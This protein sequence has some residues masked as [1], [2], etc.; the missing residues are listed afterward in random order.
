MFADDI[1][2][3]KV[4][5]ASSLRVGGFAMRCIPDAILRHRNKAEYLIIERKTTNKV[6]VPVEGWP[7]VEAQLWCYSLIDELQ[8]A[9][10]VHLIGQLWRRKFPQSL[11]LVHT[12]FLWKRSDRRHHEFC[13]ELFVEYGG[14]YRPDES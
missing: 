5:Q 1:P 9:D 7:N 12:H 11:Q 6:K 4:F 8:E 14:L 10:E 13:L 3:S 2:K